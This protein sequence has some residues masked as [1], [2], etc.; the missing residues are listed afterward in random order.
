MNEDPSPQADEDLTPPS[1]L[2]ESLGHIITVELKT[3]QLN[4]GKL[5]EA[6]EHFFERQYIH[7]AGWPCIAVRLAGSMSRNPQGQGCRLQIKIAERRQGKDREEDVSAGRKLACLAQDTLERLLPPAQ[8]PA[9][10]PRA[11]IPAKVH[12]ALTAQ[13][14]TIVSPLNTESTMKRI[15]EHNTLVFI[16]D[17]KS[18]KRQIKDAVKKLYNVQATKVNTL[19]RPDGKKKAYVWL[20]VDHDAL[21]VANK[22]GFI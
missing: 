7:R 16:V 13:F 6:A 17:I 18:N 2:H 21:D 5:A 11:Q 20:T 4:R 14:R 1:K 8:D 3:G 19:I 12:P 9:P 10:P 15:E 22:I